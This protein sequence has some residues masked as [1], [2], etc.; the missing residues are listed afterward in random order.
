MTSPDAS[1]ESRTCAA[2]SS[3]RSSFCLEA[4]DRRVCD[5]AVPCR[6]STS[7]RDMAHSAL[8]CFPPELVKQIV[9]YL[10]RSDLPATRFLNKQFD[11]AAN[12][13]LFRTIPVWISV[14]SLENLAHLSHHPFRGYVTEIVFSPLRL[15]DHKKDS[16]HLSKVKSLLEHETDS[17]SQVALRFAR[18]QSAYRAFI[19]AQRYLAEGT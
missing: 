17:M 16:K 2:N 18:Y 12:P 11:Y 13:R 6:T 10:P 5:W 7:S 15:R 14:K 4:V 1:H 9:D 19:E 8:S 3:S